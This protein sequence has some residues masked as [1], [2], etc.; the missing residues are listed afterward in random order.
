MQIN[1]YPDICTVIVLNYIK[2]ANFSTNYYET[3][4][5]EIGFRRL[6]YAHQDFQIN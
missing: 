5:I 6:P 1:N 4:N 2:H 3:G